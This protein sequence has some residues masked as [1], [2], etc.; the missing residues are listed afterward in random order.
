MVSPEA[1]AASPVSSQSS[2]GMTRDIADQNERYPELKGA[3]FQ[4]TARVLEDAKEETADEHLDSVVR[5]LM[6]KKYQEGGFGD[7]KKSTRN[8]SSAMGANWRWIVVT[9]DRCLSWDNS[10]LTRSKKKR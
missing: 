10:K 1:S 2:L 3:M 6:G 7:P 5:D 8:N 4:G 9:P